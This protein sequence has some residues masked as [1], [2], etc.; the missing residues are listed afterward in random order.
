MT[1]EV[2]GMTG[3]LSDLGGIAE[4][5]RQE[6]EAQL[7]A[8]QAAE[9]QAS[10]LTAIVEAAYLVAVADGEVSQEEADT[11]SEGI[12]AVTDANIAEDALQ[13]YFEIADSRFEAEGLNARLDAVGADIADPDCRRAAFL[14]A[15]AVAYKDS[16][17]GTKQGLALQHLARSFEIPQNEM[18]ELMAKAKRHFG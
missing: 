7:E 15:S 14:V 13:K 5:I 8:E 9:H 2:Q 10:L 4:R 17:I 11:L 16:G 6:A 12:V 18:F 3:L 1:D